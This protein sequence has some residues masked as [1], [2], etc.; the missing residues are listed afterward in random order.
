[1]IENIYISSLPFKADEELIKELFSQFGNVKTIELHADWVSPK[2]EPYANVIIDTEDADKLV[3]VLDGKKIGR[4]YIR[5][6]KR[7]GHI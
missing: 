6:H 5:V 4:N 1:M 3:D 7:A 2:F